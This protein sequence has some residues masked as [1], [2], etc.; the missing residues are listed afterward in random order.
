MAVARPSTRLAQLLLKDEEFCRDVDRRVRAASDLVDG[1]P[2]TAPDIEILLGRLRHRL[3]REVQYSVLNSL[4]YSTISPKHIER[5][6]PTVKGLLYALDSDAAFVWMKVGCLLGD[7]WHLAAGADLRK[8]LRSLLVDVVRN[9]RWSSGRRS[10]LH[11]IEH[12]LNEVPLPAGKKLLDVVREVALRDR[13]SSVRQRAYFILHNGDWWGRRGIPELH[14][15]A[16][17][18]GRDL[19][20]PQRRQKRKSRK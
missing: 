18:L 4:D 8:K 20:F 11:G 10:A 1:L 17:K 14:R 5:L 3:S 2:R 9:A 6:L 15:Y 19:Q 7:G 16:R 13:A 12:L